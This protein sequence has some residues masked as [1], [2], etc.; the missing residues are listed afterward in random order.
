MKTIKG[1]QLFLS[2]YV[3]DLKFRS[4]VT[5]VQ[6]SD[7]TKILY[8]KFES[9][10]N[11]KEVITINYK[12]YKAQ[13]NFLKSNTPKL[14]IIDEADK[15]QQEDDTL[16]YHINRG[17]YNDTFLI[18][19]NQPKITCGASDRAELIINEDRITLNYLFPEPLI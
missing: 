4:R 7:L 17:D 8:S 11:T 3:I 2:D 12:N 1:M 6:P 15:I 18:I 5:I 13:E 10:R 14:V 16:M 9:L 19:G